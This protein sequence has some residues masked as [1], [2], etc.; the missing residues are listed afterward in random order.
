MLKFFMLSFVLFSSLNCLASP[1]DQMMTVKERLRLVLWT[2]GL[3]E[4]R[5][6]VQ[7]Q[8]Q[9]LIL[10]EQIERPLRKL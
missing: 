8:E 1:L 6:V 9:K 5:K 7:P 10:P 3:E 2:E 4:Q